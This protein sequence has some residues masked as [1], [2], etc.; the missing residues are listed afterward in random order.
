MTAARLT[1]GRET[2]ELLPSR[3]AWWPARN[4]LLVSDLHLGKAAALRHHGLPVPEGDTEADL[5]RLSEA[6]RQTSARELVVCGDLF[7]APAA[8]SP[9]VLELFRSWRA[10]HAGVSVTLVPGNHDKPE[11]LPPEDLR[12]VIAGGRLDLRNPDAAAATDEGGFACVHDPVEAPGDVPCVCGH[13]HPV[14]ALGERGVAPLRAPCFWWNAERRLLVLPAFGGFTGG[15]VAR[16]ARGDRVFAVCPD[17]VL[18]VPPA[19]W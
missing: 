3:C 18:E 16:P 10:R 7:H 17:K 15:V 9:A 19:L 12:I 8:K 4:T 11:A 5:R 14:V 6:L 13:L 2:L 1:I